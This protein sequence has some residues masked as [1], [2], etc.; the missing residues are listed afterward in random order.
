MA[1]IK[2]HP[3][4]TKSGLLSA[5]ASG[6]L[7]AIT[8]KE[9]SGS[10]SSANLD[11]FRGKEHTQQAAIDGIREGKPVV[12]EAMPDL[13]TPDNNITVTVD[14]QPTKIT[15]PDMHVYTVVRADG[16]GVTL[17]NPWGKNTSP[18]APSVGPVFTMTWKD[19]HAQFTDVT[20]GATPWK[21]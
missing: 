5:G 19:F 21:K 17:S 3:S 18:G 14:G 1:Y 16:D 7:S 2:A 8:M 11:F 15:L 10:A 13:M 12:A 9:I 4:G 20:V 6:S